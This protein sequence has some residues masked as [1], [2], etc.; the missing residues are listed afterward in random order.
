MINIINN[1][2]D[3]MRDQ[4]H[5]VIKTENASDIEIRGVAGLENSNDSYVKIVISDTGVGMTQKT[6]EKVFE[7]FFST[8]AFE[9]NTGL[10]L[11]M[12]YGTVK[13]HGGAVIIRSAIN[14]G[15]SVTL[16]LPIYKRKSLTVG[17]TLNSPLSTTHI[18]DLSI[19][20]VDDEPLVRKS[21][22]RILNQF[23]FDVLTAQSGKKAVELYKEHKDKID[24][25]LLDLIMP[26]MDG[27]Q[28]FNELLSINRDIK[29]IFIS[30]FSKDSIR[31][32]NLLERGAMDFVQKPFTLNEISSVIHKTL[33]K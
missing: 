31:V 24:L 26:E 6:L 11:S 18:K 12:V 32:D 7:P 21:T 4:G 5:L 3:A 16:Y 1:S 19:L 9:G 8:K 14:Q 10:G 30:A 15:T 33:D 2:I 22:S 20:I 27:E 25:V 28:T 13:N 29:V 17:T 23:G